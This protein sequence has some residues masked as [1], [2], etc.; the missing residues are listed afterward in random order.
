MIKELKS[1]VIY[2]IML[3]ALCIVYVEYKHYRLS[4]LLERAEALTSLKKN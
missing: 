1:I 2:G 4:S 3:F